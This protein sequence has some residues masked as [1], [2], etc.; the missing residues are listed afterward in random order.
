MPDRLAGKNALSGRRSRLKQSG[1]TEER[2]IGV[3]AMGMSVAIVMST[4]R[5]VAVD[6]TVHLYRGE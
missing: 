4:I 5:A 6:Q 3:T 2:P 1:R